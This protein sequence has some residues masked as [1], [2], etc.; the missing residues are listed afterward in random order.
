MLRKH[1]WEGVWTF[2]A[3]YCLDIPFATIVFSPPS[4]LSLA[5]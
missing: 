1:V 2:P 5:H 4:S 3:A